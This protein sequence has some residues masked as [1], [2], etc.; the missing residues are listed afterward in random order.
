MRPKLRQPDEVEQGGDRGRAWGVDGSGQLHLVRP[1]SAGRQQRVVGQ[2]VP[3]QNA[4]DGVLQ[5]G[6]KSRSVKLF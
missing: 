3:E 6:P 1:S 2:G 4:V 5:R